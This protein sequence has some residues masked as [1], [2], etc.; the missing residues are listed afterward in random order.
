MA[1]KLG[2]EFIGTFWLVLG[3][4]G[5]A[6]LAAAFP[7]VGIG[8][9]GVSFAFGFSGLRP[10]LVQFWPESFTNGSALRIKSTALSSFA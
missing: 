4:C 7:E 5:A 6:L 3:G 1:R 9:L 10:L 8:L 2:A